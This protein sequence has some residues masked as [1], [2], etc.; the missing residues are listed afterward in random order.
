MT[1]RRLNF[2]CACLQR[3]CTLPPDFLFPSK[4]MRPDSRHGFLFLKYIT[5]HLLKS[6]I[7]WSRN[8]PGFQPFSFILLVHISVLCHCF[9]LSVSHSPHFFSLF[10][11]FSK[12]F[13][14]T[15]IF[16]CIL[17]CKIAQV[18]QCHGI[19]EVIQSIDGQ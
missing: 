8:L 10:I 11:L 18:N 16:S 14:V 6:F 13:R 7:S 2:R 5:V 3:V 12:I 9:C 15:E 17:N 19:A 4:V 1:V